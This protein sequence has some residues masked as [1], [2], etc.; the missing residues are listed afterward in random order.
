[1]HRRTF[2]CTACGRVRRRE[3]PGQFNWP[4]C[5]GQAMQR[6]TYEQ[7]DG[8][9]KLSPR[10]RLRWLALGAQLLRVRSRGPQKWRPA[11]TLRQVSASR[12]QLQILARQ[13]RRGNPLRRNV[14]A[15]RS[16]RPKS[17]SMTA[18]RAESR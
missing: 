1:M 3:L 7:A 16:K 14:I 18:R 15:P 4:S 10:D 9:A 17:R 13:S 8:A 2:V 12:E 11:M 5:C 6:L